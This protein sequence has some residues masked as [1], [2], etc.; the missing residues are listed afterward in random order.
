M[1]CLKCFHVCVLLY[2]FLFSVENTQLRIS[3]KIRRDWNW[4]KHIL[5][6]FLLMMTCTIQDHESHKGEQGAFLLVNASHELRWEGTRSCPVTAVQDKIIRWDNY[7]R[8]WLER[9]E[10]GEIWIMNRFILCTLLLNIIKATKLT[11]MKYSGHIAWWGKSKILVEK[12]DH[13][14]DLGIV[15]MLKK[16][17]TRAWTGIIRP[18]IG[19]NG[20]PS[21]TW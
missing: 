18:R 13:L 4:S 7:L 21:W 12:S 16:Q 8:T 14:E 20:G 5:L 3:K 15:W 10:D 19:C 17:C 6:C 9:K 2:G 11:R 1:Q